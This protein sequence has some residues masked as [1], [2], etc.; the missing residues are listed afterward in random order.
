MTNNQVAPIGFKRLA[1]VAVLA[2]LAGVLVD[3]LGEQFLPGFLVNALSKAA[4]V[5]VALVGVHAGRNMSWRVALLV[6]LSIAASAA[7]FAWLLS[8]LRF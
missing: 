1:A 6:A 4:I 5:G 8:I 3:V 7:G 2:A